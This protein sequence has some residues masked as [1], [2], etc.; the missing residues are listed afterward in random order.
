MALSLASAVRTAATVLAWLVPACCLRTSLE[1][2][3][4]PAFLRVVRSLRVLDRP[5]AADPL[6]WWSVLSPSSPLLC[7]RYAL[8]ITVIM[9]NRFLQTTGGLRAPVSLTLMHMIGCTIFS[10]SAVYMCG[11][12]FTPQP[13]ISKRQLMKVRETALSSSP[14]SGRTRKQAPGGCRRLCMLVT[15]M[16]GGA[17]RAK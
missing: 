13:L 8:N 15:Q 4:P 6:N 12:N 2:A 14:A 7:G 5:T 10:N 11:A 17:C 1:P 16:R 9:T 3:S